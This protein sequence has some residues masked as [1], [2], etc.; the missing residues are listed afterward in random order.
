MYNH[1]YILELIK[2]FWNFC[3]KLGVIFSKS[4]QLVQNILE[5]LS[6]FFEVT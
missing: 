3:G 2:S 4:K 1:T 5:F 6:I